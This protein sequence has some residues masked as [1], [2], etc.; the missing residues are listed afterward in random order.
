MSDRVRK[1]VP[2]DAMALVALRRE[3]LEREP[4][5]FAASPDDDHGL[6]IELVRTALANDHEHV[7]AGAASG[8]C[9]S[10]Q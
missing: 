6:S 5:A 7:H 9:S 4:L 8:D 10:R 3:A 2:D 1:L